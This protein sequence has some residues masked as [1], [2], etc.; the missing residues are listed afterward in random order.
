[1]DQTGSKLIF[2]AIARIVF[3]FSLHAQTK[4]SLYLDDLRELI[5]LAE[6]QFSWSP[7][8]KVKAFFRRRVI[9][10]RLHG[11]I[12]SK[13]KERL[14]LLRREKIVP[15]RKNPLSILDLMLRDQVKEDGVKQE[16]TKVDDLPQED[17]D[18][19]VTK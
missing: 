10:K 14:T 1:M 6:A 12:I 7:V 5:R 9:L 11:S 16:G 4:G 17:L 8:I 15:S 18:L 2:D 13:I 3:N 19:L